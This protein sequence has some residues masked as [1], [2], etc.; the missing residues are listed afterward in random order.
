MI[1]DAMRKQLLKHPLD[2]ANRG[3][4]PV[5]QY[6]DGTLIIMPA[7]PVQAQTMKNFLTDY[8]TYIGLRINFQKSTLVLVNAAP[9]LCQNIAS[10]FGCSVAT[11]P[12]TYLGLLLGT[13]KPTVH[14][15][16][17]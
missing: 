11:M 7:C 5:I 8:A 12:F 13:T 10:I 15:L 2:Y 4:F 1:N 16:A 17:P 3:D 6:V 14:D 9:D